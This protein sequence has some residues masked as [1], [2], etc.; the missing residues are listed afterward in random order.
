MTLHCTWRDMMREAVER[1]AAAGAEHPARDAR[2]LMA[3]ALGIEPIDVI[4]RE[5]D[6]VDPVGLGAFE[7]VVQRRLAGEPVSRIR[8]WREFYGRRFIVTPDVLDPRPET[9]LLVEQGIKRLP[10]N[11]RLLDLGTGSGCI[12]LSV[13]AERKDADGVA[14]D[15]STAALDVA[16]ANASALGLA[17]SV[18][19]LEGSWDRELPGPFDLALSN[20]P[21]IPA[22]DVAGL[23]LDVRGHDPHIALTP[24]GDGLDAYRAILAA[25]PRW[26]RPGGAIGF[27]FGMGQSGAVFAL[28]S[29]AGLE[30]VEVFEDLAGIA[31]AAFGRRPG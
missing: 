20:P 27:E 31:R 21:Y 22:E 1:L 14:L 2:L 17:D 10:Q 13:L 9:E 6:N 8:G 26:L 29:D 24:G 18:T 23:A 28:M 4:V 3:H 12:L 25:M 19:F 16:R 5:T 15:I 30:A 7:A 11:G